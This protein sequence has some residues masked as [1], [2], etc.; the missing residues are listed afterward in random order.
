[1]STIFEDNRISDA[2]MGDIRWNWVAGNWTRKKVPEAMLLHM[3]ICR[4]I[5]MMPQMNFC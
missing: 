4:N 1:M 5:A 3:F 2:A